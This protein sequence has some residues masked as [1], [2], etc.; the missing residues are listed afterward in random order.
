MDDRRVAAK[1]LRDEVNNELRRLPDQDMF[2]DS[3]DGGKAEC[4]GT[5]AALDQ[6]LET[7]EVKA[8]DI[9][10]DDEPEGTEDGGWNDAVAWL[11]GGSSELTVHGVDRDW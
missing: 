7:G 6:F 11:N 8:K 2:G 4:R 1:K 5:L 9:H 3:N 10:W